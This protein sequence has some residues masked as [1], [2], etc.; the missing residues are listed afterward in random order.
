M[1]LNVGTHR[2]PEEGIASPGA[3]A[4]GYEL[5]NVGAKN[6]TQVLC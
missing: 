4:G 6:Q 5:S 3:G 2:N 1:L